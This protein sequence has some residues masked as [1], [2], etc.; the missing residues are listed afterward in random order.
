M[1]GVYHEP[2]RRISLFEILLLI[3][4]ILV[5]IIGFILIRQ[6]FLSEG[7]SISWLMVGAIFSWLTLLI[8]FVV[9]ELNADVKEELGH[10]LREQVDE[11]RML[12]ELHHALLEEIRALRDDLKSVRKASGKNRKEAA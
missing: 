2:S 6:T 11:T 7:K 4:A 3:L 10:I 9:S 1:L 12:K 8:L 5:L